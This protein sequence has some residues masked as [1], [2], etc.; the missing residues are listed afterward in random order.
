MRL[1]GQVLATEEVLADLQDRRQRETAVQALLQRGLPSALA[2]HVKVIDARSQE[3][4]LIVASGAAA[5]LVKQR[6]P[7]LLGK[8][9][10]EGW[11]FTGI[12]VRVQARQTE[13]QP[14]KTSTK[15][16]DKAAGATLE[17]LATRLGES[18]LALALRRLARHAPDRPGSDDH[19]QALER[20]KNQDAEQ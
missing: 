15:Q 18:P 10:G 8:L 11:E 1:L 3:L 12:R 6:A 19:H 5:A 2:V 20:V 16:L 13:G 17:R 14:P 4:E 7:D 9:A